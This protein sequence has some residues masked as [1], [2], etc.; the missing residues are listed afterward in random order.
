MQAY[1]EHERAHSRIIKNGSNTLEPK[2]TA[3]VLNLANTDFKL[4]FDCEITLCL[5]NSGLSK[6]ITEQITFKWSASTRKFKHENLNCMFIGL[7][8][9]EL[10]DERL[11]IAASVA[12][13]API[14]IAILSR[15]GKYTLPNYF[16]HAQRY[17]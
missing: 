17:K 2:T 12:V 9:K 5:W 16:P 7:T 13:I 15:N 3:L 8:E 1:R 10:M 4:H 6:A 14:D 11:E